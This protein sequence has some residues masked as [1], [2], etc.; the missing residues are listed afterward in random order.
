MMQLYQDQAIII[1]EFTW[2]HYDNTQELESIKIIIM[3]LLTA[4]ILIVGCDW[5]SREQQKVSI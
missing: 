3:S 5:R 4:N 1:W 2:L